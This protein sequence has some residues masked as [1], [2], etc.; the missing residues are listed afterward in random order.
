M[1]ETAAGEYADEVDMDASEAPD[2]PR[3]IAALERVGSWHRKAGGDLQGQTSELQGE[4]NE[5]EARIALL[6]TELLELRERQA[7]IE[8]RLEELVELSVGLEL[9]HGERLKMAVV[10]AIAGDREIVDARAELLTRAEDERQAALEAMLA[11]PEVARLVEEY[12]QFTEVEPTLDLL[13]SGYRKAILSHHEAVRRRLQP[14]FEAIEEELQP[15]DADPAAISVLA[16]LDFEDGR[17]LA[18]VVLLPVAYQTYRD[19]S[20]AGERLPGLLAARV[21][22]AVSSVLE[23]LGC[24]DAAIRYADIDGN[25]ALQVWLGDGDGPDGDV[26]SHLQSAFTALRSGAAELDA[27]NLAVHLAWVPPATIEA[28]DEGEEDADARA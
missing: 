11:D 12:E 22:G 18:L 21:V 14:L 27:V 3:L 20:A 19:W 25:L 16:S 17:P 2:V 6:E 13:P 8:G 5:A 24:P 7:E 9:E 4:A 28:L 26:Q 1:S 15:T 23:R 10:E